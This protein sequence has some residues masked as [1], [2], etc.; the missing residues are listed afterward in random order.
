MITLTYNKVCGL[1]AR[2]ENLE[3]RLM[4]LEAVNRGGPELVDM[5]SPLIESENE[6]GQLRKALT[7]ANYRNSVVSNIYQNY[8]QFN[9]F[10][11]QA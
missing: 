2:M 5:K 4:G 9:E 1:V 3:K 7:D 10:C 8:F 6:Y 11:F